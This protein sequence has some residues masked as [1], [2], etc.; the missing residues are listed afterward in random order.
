[1]GYIISLGGHD[2]E[3]VGGRGRVCCRCSGAYSGLFLFGAPQQ[4]S[5]RPQS[6]GGRS[7]ADAVPKKNWMPFDTPAASCLRSRLCAC[8]DLE[9]GAPL[10]CSCPGKAR[11]SQKRLEGADCSVLCG[12]LGDRAGGVTH[13]RPGCCHAD[14]AAR[15]KPRTHIGEPQPFLIPLSWLFLSPPCGHAAPPGLRAQFTGVFQAVPA[16]KL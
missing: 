14:N 10:R 9:R 5:P 16:P 7:I 2:R 8:L 12:T 3:F 6:G 4:R 11:G 13:P 15:F 1:M